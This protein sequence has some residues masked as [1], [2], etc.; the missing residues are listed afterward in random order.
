[1]QRV[2]ILSK[3]AL[4][5]LN[6]SQMKKTSEKNVESD[7]SDIHKMDAFNVCNH[8]FEYCMICILH[9]AFGCNLLEQL[10]EYLT[11]IHVVCFAFVCF[12]ISH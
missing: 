4:Q 1:M 8:S 3:R 5:L 10:D 12:L 2:L 6:I 7:C 9:R 11:Y